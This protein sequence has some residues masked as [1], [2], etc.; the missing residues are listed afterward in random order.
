MDGDQVRVVG[1]VAWVAW[2][3]ESA[4][5]KRMDDAR[6]E[7]GG[8]EGPSDGLV[9]ASGS[10]DG[11]ELVAEV[12]LANGLAE[13]ADGIVEGGA[14]VF[15]DGGWQEDV[16]EE[17]GEHPL[18]SRFGTIDADDAEVLGSDFLDA[19][20]KSTVWFLDG[21]CGLGPA[22]AAGTD[23]GIYL[24]RK[25]EGYPDSLGWQLKCD[26]FSKKTNIPGVGSCPAL[27][28]QHLFRLTSSFQE[29]GILLSL[30]VR[31]LVDGVAE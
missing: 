14:V 10:F 3:T 2:L 31:R 28:S 12:V 4:G 27:F 25:G 30:T 23:H 19:G 21:L 24:R 5:S 6:L 13:L 17:V 29:E 11:D 20:V 7:A 9:I 1:L 18:G 8:G 26:S 22:S 15:D 16:S